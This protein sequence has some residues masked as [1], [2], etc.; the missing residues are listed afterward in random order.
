MNSI[1]K[2]EPEITPPDEPGVAPSTP[3]I[4]PQPERNN[5][6]PPSPEF[7]EKEPEPE[8]APIREI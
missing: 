2:K 1:P 4:I 5:P 6:V 7:P 3:E 8:I